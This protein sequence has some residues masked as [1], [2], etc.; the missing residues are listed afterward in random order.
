MLALRLD[1]VEHFLHMMTIFAG[2]ALF[3]QKPGDF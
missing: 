3:V 1:W 2:V